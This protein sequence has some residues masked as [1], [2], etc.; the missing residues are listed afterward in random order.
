MTKEVLNTIVRGIKGKSITDKE[1][2]FGKNKLPA[3]EA[4]YE[5]PMVHIRQLIILD[6][7]RVYQI[8]VAGATKDEVISKDADKFFSSFHI[9]K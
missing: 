4:L 8:I 2:A 6:G 1:V 7:Q 9:T 3:R 5:L